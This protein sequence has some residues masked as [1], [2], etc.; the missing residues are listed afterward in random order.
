MN[1][2]KSIGELASA[3]RVYGMSLRKVRANAELTGGHRRSKSRRAMPR[4]AVVA[5]ALAAALSLSTVALAATGVINFDTVI[6][7]VFDKGTTP[8]IQTGDELNTLS[9]SGEVTVDA[10]AAFLDEARDGAYVQLR[11]KDTTGTKLTESLALSEGE[12]VIG[13]AAKN[14]ATDTLIFSNAGQR[15]NTGEVSVNVVDKNTVVASMFI[16]GIDGLDV[17]DG[18]VNGKARIRFD[19]IASGIRVYLDA[20]TTGFNIGA[21]LGIH[22]PTVVPGAEFMEIVGISRKDGSLTITR[23]A[24]DATVHGWGEASLGLQKPNGEIIWSPHS[25]FDERSMRWTDDFELGDADPDDLTLVWTGR[26]AD[27]AFTGDWTFDVSGENVIAPRKMSGS[28]DGN[29]A[30]ALIGATSVEIKVFADYYANP[31]PFD[32][33]E[34]GAVAITLTDGTT[35]IP[36]AEATARD[37]EGATFK[38]TMPFINPDEVASVTFG[39]ETLDAAG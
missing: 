2:A 28:V 24:S 6:D 26:R 14:V 1:K 8:Y 19:A 17:A 33:H 25:S 37:P 7:S 35:V 39:G 36:K 16:L 15:V 32:P 23:Q 12:R 13:A 18:K 20:Q 22:E 31:M 9:S 29:A 38:Y 27:V 5:A 3:E 34:E 30:Q 11:I 21:N 4:F 10:T